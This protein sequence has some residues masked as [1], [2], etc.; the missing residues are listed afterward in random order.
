MLKNK[1]RTALKLAVAP[2][3]DYGGTSDTHFVYP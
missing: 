3:T 1:G 2:D